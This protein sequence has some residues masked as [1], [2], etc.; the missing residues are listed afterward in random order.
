MLRQ[1]NLQNNRGPEERILKS[2][3]IPTGIPSW[4]SRYPSGADAGIC[5]SCA[6]ATKSPSDLWVRVGS[7]AGSR[8][9]GF[10]LQNIGID[11]SKFKED[12]LNA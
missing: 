7:A 11:W 9:Q 6:L 2:T 3:D 12:S 10:K 8:R 1:A 5:F 4:Q